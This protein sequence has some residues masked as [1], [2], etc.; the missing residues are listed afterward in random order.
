MPAVP[1]KDGPIESRTLAQS[2]ELSSGVIGIPVAA[3][4]PSGLVMAQSASPG[5]GVAPGDL[6]LAVSTTDADVISV[7][8]LSPLPPAVVDAPEH[9]VP[10]VT[11]LNAAHDHSEATLVLPMPPLSAN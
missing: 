4:C 2:R 11:K 9:A 5:P 1:V 10:A 6:S 7:T 8:A 3:S